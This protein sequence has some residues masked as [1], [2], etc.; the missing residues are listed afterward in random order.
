[1][2]YEKAKEDRRVDLGDDDGCDN[3]DPACIID[4]K[5]K[6]HDSNAEL[7][8][9]IAQD[10]G[11]LTLLAR[12]SLCGLIPVALMVEECDVGGSDSAATIAGT[13]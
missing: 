1:M 6:Q 12:V 7:Y 3:D 8:G 10:I 4:C 11:W 13:A 9:H 2:E 5:T